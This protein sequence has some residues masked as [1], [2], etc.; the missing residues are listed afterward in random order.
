MAIVN[1]DWGQVAANFYEDATRR[2]AAAWDRLYGPYARLI[3]SSPLTRNLIAESIA[4][5]YDV[6][7]DQLVGSASDAVPTSDAVPGL[8]VRLRPF[9]FDSATQSVGPRYAPVLDPSWTVQNPP[10]LVCVG[11]G[12][13]HAPGACSASSSSALEAKNISFRIESGRLSVTLTLLQEAQQKFQAAQQ[14]RLRTAQGKLP[15]APTN[16]G[17]TFHVGLRGTSGRLLFVSFDASV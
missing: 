4:R 17:R 7:R 10:E 6:S 5:S 14:R 8:E 15:A 16:G 3:A 13:S 12:P 11:L 1:E 9:T 2:W